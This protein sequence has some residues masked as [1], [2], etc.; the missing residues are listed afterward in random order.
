[1]AYN[2]GNLWWLLALPRRELV[3]DESVATAGENRRGIAK[4]GRKWA[5]SAMLVQIADRW[6]LT[7]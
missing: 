3:A 4:A 5:I 7:G 1:L 6:G 2:L